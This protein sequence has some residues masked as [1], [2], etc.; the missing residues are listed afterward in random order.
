MS[1]MRR[2]LDDAMAKADLIIC[3]L[4]G[5]MPTKVDTKNMSALCGRCGVKLDVGYDMYWGDTEVLGEHK[6]G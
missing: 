2:F 5:H 6:D 3:W 4:F 1:L